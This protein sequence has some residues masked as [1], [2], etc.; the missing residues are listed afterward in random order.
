VRVPFNFTQLLKTPSNIFASFTN[1]TE[2]WPEPFKSQI[3]LIIKISKSV[4]ANKVN[5]FNDLLHALPKHKT[6]T[7]TKQQFDIITF[8]VTMVGLH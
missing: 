1:Y 6:L 5:D 8:G 3:L 2:I 4:L 7:C